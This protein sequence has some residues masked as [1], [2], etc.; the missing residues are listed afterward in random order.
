MGEIS[1][2][3]WMSSTRSYLYVFGR[4]SEKKIS[5]LTES[6]RANKAVAAKLNTLIEF[7]YLNLELQN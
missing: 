6:V 2:P 7:A 3:T 1:C 5:A 4:M